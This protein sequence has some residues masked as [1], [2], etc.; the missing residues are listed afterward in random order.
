MDG[1]DAVV[2]AFVKELFEIDRIL[3]TV[4]QNVAELFG[5]R[6]FALGTAFQLFIKLEIVLRIRHPS[7]LIDGAVFTVFKLIVSLFNSVLYVV[8]CSF[9]RFMCL[10]LFE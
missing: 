9:K 10:N 2:T 6:L 5:E 8:A 4:A 7:F 3:A 1:F